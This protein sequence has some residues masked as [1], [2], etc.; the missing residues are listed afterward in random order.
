[1]NQTVQGLDPKLAE[2]YNRVMGMELPKTSN[3]PPPQPT[4]QPAQPASQTVP[5]P[6]TA[7]T[8]YVSAKKGLPWWIFLLAGVVF[9]ILYAF[10]WM[11][12]FNVNL[13]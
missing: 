8:S 12:L 6:Q 11:R 7:S 13:L 10:F 3:P 9:F 2:T 5:S 4:Q 1:M